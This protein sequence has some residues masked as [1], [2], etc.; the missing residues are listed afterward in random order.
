VTVRQRFLRETRAAARI[1]HPYVATVYRVGQ[2]PE[3]HPLATNSSDLVF[4]SPSAQAIGRIYLEALDSEFLDCGV[5]LTGPIADTH[6]VQFAIVTRI[7]QNDTGGATI[8]VIVDGFAR[9]RYHN[10]NPVP[11]RGTGK[12]E[13]EIAELLK[14]LAGAPVNGAQFRLAASA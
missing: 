8:E 14:V 6:M 13:G 7:H 3:D 2:T 5:G 1:H 10:M 4:I 11:C 12:L 9:D